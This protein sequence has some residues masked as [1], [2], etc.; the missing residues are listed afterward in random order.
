MAY[1]EYV[2]DMDSVQVHDNVPMT[3]PLV[4]AEDEYPGMESALDA[5]FVA[6]GAELD[7]RDRAHSGSLRQAG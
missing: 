4:L 1:R 5:A 3:G 6:Y 2:D 7:A